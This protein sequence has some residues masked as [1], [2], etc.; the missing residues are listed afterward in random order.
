MKKILK[1]YKSTLILLLAI[2][3]FLNSALLLFFVYS[4]EKNQQ[5]LMAKTENKK[6]QCSNLR[7]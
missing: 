7:L 4:N 3:I 5:G 1:N 2:I 6:N